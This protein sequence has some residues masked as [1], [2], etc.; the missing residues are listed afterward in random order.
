VLEASGVLPAMPKLAEPFG[1]S[2]FTTNREA[3]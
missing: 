2:V 3:L 1:I